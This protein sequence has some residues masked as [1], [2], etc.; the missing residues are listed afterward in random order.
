MD[1]NIFKSIYEGFQGIEISAVVRERLSLA[2]AQATDIQ[3][4]VTL[5]EA[6][7]EELKSQI[8][9]EQVNHAETKRKLAEINKKWAEDVRLFRGIEFRRGH[10]TGGIWMAFCPSCHLPLVEQVNHK[11]FAICSK[12]CGWLMMELDRRLSEIAAELG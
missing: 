4:K 8:K 11:I 12:H 2:E 6:E 7:N 5:L 1:L 3:K 9:Y 10:R